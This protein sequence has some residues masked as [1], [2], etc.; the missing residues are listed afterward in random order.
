MKKCPTLGINSQKSPRAK[1]GKI[2]T[3]KAQFESLKHLY[4]TTFENLNY[5]RQTLF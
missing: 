2:S 1:N 5:L 3:P 4:Q